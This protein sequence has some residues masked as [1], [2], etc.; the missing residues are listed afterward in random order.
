M[1]FLFDTI[2][3]P[4]IFYKVEVCGPS[5]T[6]TYWSLASSFTFGE[7]F[8]T[9]LFLH[10]SQDLHLGGIQLCNGTNTPILLFAPLR[11]G[12]LEPC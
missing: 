5:L 9:T 12:L 10:K 4:T 7:H 11:G 8:Q 6:L 2:I 1:L 3:K